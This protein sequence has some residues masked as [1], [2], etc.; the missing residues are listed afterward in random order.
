[1]VCRRLKFDGDSPPG[2]GG[3]NRLNH[4]GFA[5]ARPSCGALIGDGRFLGVVGFIPW[6]LRGKSPPPCGGVSTGRG[7]A[8]LFEPVEYVRLKNLFG[9]CRCYTISCIRS[10]S[11]I[12]GLIFSAISRFGVC[13]RFS[14]RSSSCWSSSRFLF[15]G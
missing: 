1:M 13:W 11:P 10:T 15:G 7:C 4:L 12:A 8:N 3:H 9:C 2:A 14:F 6:S 5:P